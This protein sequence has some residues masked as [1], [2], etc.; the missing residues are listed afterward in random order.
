MSAD[1][2]TPSRIGIRTLKSTLIAG[3][4]ALAGAVC[5]ATV[6]EID[7]ARDALTNAE[8][9]ILQRKW[10]RLNWRGHKR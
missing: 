10:R 4:A 9:T 6:A 5:A 7:V 1:S 2:S 3:C 8:L